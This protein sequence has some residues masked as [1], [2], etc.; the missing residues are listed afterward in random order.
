VKGKHQY[1]EEYC[2]AF[3]AH[4]RKL[5]IAK[6]YGMREFAIIADM[7]YSTLSRLERGVGNTTISTALF[8][9]N[10]LGVTHTELY[11]FKFPV[12]RN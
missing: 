10:A 2:K 5:R 9:A 1:D 12:K 8:I 4:F 11:N 3:G 6:G 7:E